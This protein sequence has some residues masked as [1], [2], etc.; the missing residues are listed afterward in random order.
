MPS[1]YFLGRDSHFRR[2]HEVD[3]QQ[4]VGQRSVGIVKERACG[5]AEL[6]AASPTLVKS[7][8]LSGFADGPKP[9]Y[10]GG[11][12]ALGAARTIRPA[13]PPQMLQARLFARELF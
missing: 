3:H 13:N 10:I 12:Y 9:G 2:I 5:G 8:N 7:P 11:G 6:A 4:P 1:I